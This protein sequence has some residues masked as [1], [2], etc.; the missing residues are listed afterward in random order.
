MK[1]RSLFFNIAIVLMVLIC[2]SGFSFLMPFRI[3]MIGILAITIILCHINNDKLYF[4]FDKNSLLFL[5]FI[6]LMFLGIRTS[7]DKIETIKFICVYLVGF[8]MLIMPMGEKYN[9]K[10]FKGMSVCIR[11]IAI[12]IIINALIPNLFSHYF[13]FLISGGSSR[14]ATE[15]NNHVYSGLMGEKAEAAYIIVIGIVLLLSECIAE[16]KM[17]KENKIWLLIYLIALLLPAKRML[18]AIGVLICV[19]FVLIGIEGKRKFS[20]LAGFTLLGIIIL[21]L[22]TSIPT[23]STLVSRFADNSTDATNNGR[24][25]LWERAIEMYQERP[26]LGYGYGSFNAYTSSKGIILTSDGNWEAHAHN[27]YYQL[28]GEMGII[29]LLTFL[30]IIIYNMII[31]IK[32]YLRRKK[33]K[34]NDYVFLFIGFSILVITIVYGCSGNCIYYTNQMI[35]LF[36]SLSLCSYLNRKHLKKGDINEK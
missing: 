26:L 25:Y 7:Y 28:L 32:L 24:T 3:V 23:F 16:K 1:Q 21:L 19:G 31:Y 18:F 36:F 14:I 34:S 2:C 6:L 27:I 20:I 30:T 35:L 33:I 12:S 8:I 11:I 29:G 4:S 13:P 22:A 5:L 9:I 17:T 15:I 10:V